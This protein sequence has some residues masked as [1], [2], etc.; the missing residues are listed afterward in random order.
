MKSITFA[1]KTSAKILEI[2]KNFKMFV[3]KFAVIA[4]LLISRAYPQEMAES[5][6]QSMDGT[7]N[8]L[9]HP[10]WGSVGSRYRQWPLPIYDGPGQLPSGSKRPN[11]RSIS[12]TLFA[13][14]PFLSDPSGRS[15]LMP[16]WGLMLHLDVTFAARN[17][18]ES[19]RL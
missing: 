3:A 12:S 1:S 4:M 7:G 17:K 18:C 2:V 9:N 15:D 5:E 19:L 8:N 16:A 6:V 13:Q 14:K 11:P 10:E